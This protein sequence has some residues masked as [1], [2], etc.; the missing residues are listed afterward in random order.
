M[1]T[2]GE[3]SLQ[4]RRYFFAFFGRT[5]QEAG[6]ERKTRDGGRRCR[7][8]CLDVSCRNGLVYSVLAF[9]SDV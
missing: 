8:A 1:Q 7:L 9:A 2:Q 3:N 4:N 5:K 6:V